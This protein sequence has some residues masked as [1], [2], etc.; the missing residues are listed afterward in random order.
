MAIPFYGQN[1]DGDA[2]DLLSNGKLV[3]VVSVAAGVH[4]TLTANDSGKL[5][6]IAPNSTEV[7]LPRC[8]AGMHFTIVLSGDYDTAACLVNQGHAD[9]DFVGAF[10][11]STQGE[12]AGTDADPAAAANTKITFAAA[13]LAGDKVHL[14][15]D[16]TKWYVSAFAQVY[17]AITF[18]N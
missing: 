13:G 2:L 1:K 17:N 16:G 5:I 9:D 18:D 14:V 12:S 8:A 3:G 11:G 15:S 4:Q 6:V 10:Y 7:T